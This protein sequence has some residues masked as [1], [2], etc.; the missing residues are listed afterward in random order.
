MKHCKKI[1]KKKRQYCAG[2]LVDEVIIEDRNITPVLEGV[3]FGEE[4]TE[5]YKAMAAI[6]TVSGKTFFDGINTE[7]NVTHIIGLRF[8]ATVTAECWINFNG[9]RIDILDL[10]NL[11]ERNEWMEATCVERGL[12]TLDASQI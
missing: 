11:D 7:I 9:R 3:D 10:E 6:N 5:K 8:D 2:D 4:F 12:D 1:R